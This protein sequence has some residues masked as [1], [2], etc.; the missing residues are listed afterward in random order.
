[1]T[2][3][4]LAGLALLQLMLAMSPGPAA[5]LTIRTAASEGLRPALLL[6]LGLTCGVLVWAMAALA[7]LS[8]VFELAPWVQTGLRIAGGLFLIWIGLSL[9]RHAAEPMP[10]ADDLP[11]RGALRAV[12]LGLWTNLANPKALAYFAAVFTGIIPQDMTWMDGA[13]ILA[14]IFVVETGWYAFMA[15]VFSRRQPRRAYARIK[16]RAERCFG[17]VLGIFGTRI[18]IG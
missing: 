4:A 8:L 18:A 9:W 7:G 11:P 6:N 5:V 12:W 10:E 3:T 1:M 13:M 2:L 14:V 17:A 16:T 15:L